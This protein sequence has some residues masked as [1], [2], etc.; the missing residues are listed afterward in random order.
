[1]GLYATRLAARRDAAVGRMDFEWRPKSILGESAGLLW[2]GLPNEGEAGDPNGVESGD[3]CGKD[4]AV[5][6]LKCQAIAVSEGEGLD[7]VAGGSFEGQFIAA[8][9]VVEVGVGLV[10]VGTCVA[11]AA[12][13]VIA[14][15]RRGVD[16]VEVEE[17]S[18]A[19]ALFKPLEATR[20][21]VDPPFEN[22]VALP[23]GDGAGAPVVV[24]GQGIGTG[25]RRRDVIGRGAARAQEE[26]K[27]DGEL[28]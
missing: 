13:Q 24:A 14:E 3:R 15:D 16:R 19:V 26:G 9:D 12:L 6:G 22:R 4:G 11:P 21:A 18:D 25:P 28:Y 1:M 20:R 17:G 23:D 27:G 7:G 2:R 8:E 10:W 5:L